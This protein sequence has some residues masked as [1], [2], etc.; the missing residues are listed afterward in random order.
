MVTLLKLSRVLESCPA[1]DTLD[2]L[3]E[4]HDLEALSTQDNNPRFQEDKI[5]GFRR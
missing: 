5:E 4:I 1:R 3:S 2:V